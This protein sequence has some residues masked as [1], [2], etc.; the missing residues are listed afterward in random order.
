MIPL[1]RDTSDF[2]QHR[3]T[4]PVPKTIL[5]FCRSGCDPAF[6]GERLVLSEVEGSR[7]TEGGGEDIKRVMLDSA[8]AGVYIHGLTGDL[9][10][11][12]KGEM[13]MIAG[14]MMEK[15]PQALEEILR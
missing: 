15:I 9:A 7:T 1:K 5:R 14:D 6:H 13:G 12:E 10:K 11:E 8:C 4:N 3:A 2:P